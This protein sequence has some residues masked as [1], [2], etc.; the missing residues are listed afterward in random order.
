MITT[1]HIENYV[2]IDLLD[3]EFQRGLNIITGETGA[4]KSIL[5][6]AIGMLL[7]GR[8]DSSAVKNGAANCVIEAHFE[9]AD[10]NLQPLFDEY[11]L[12]YDDTM[13]VR[14][15]ITAQG[16]S[17][18][19]INELPV[20]LAQLKSIGERLIDIH[21]QHQ[22]LLLGDGGF[23][24]DVVDCVAQNE[25]LI[26]DY[27]DLM[28]SVRD[29]RA[30]HDAA[31]EELNRARRDEEFMRYQYEQLA[32]AKLKA[33]EKEELEA[34]EAVMAN[35]TQ[36]KEALWESCSLLDGESDACVLTSLRR[37]EGVLESISQHSTVAADLSERIS[38]A[39]Y[40]LK[41]ISEELSSLDDEISADPSE[42]ERLQARLDT[43]YTL[44]RKHN[45]EGVEPLIELRDSLAAKLALIDGS[46]DSIKE[47]AAQLDAQTKKALAVA[48]KLSKRRSAAL[49]G[50]RKNILSQLS[51]LGMEGARIEIEL[52]QGKELLYNGIDTIEFMFCANKGGKLERIAKVAS[53]GEMSRLMLSLKSLMASHRSLPTIIF[54]EID[55]G[56]SGSVAD[57]MGEIM[58]RLSAGKQIINITHLPQVAAKGNHHFYV[59]KTDK[60]GVTVT[61]IRKLSGQERVDKIAEMLSASRVTDAARKQAEELLGITGK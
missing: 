11:D 14:R 41:D 12:E 61:V 18:S 57:K 56:V 38:S 51:Q 42:L 49:P 20:T 4:G 48:S 31:V 3:I 45:V 16:K 2:L 8:T 6:G 33:G 1:L 50:I 25:A 55:T 58:E 39:Y 54:D 35:A 23:Q 21:S 46:D 7:G 52:T 36:I 9:V 19:Y 28:A 10:Y 32:E 37:V 34:Q 13:T 30:R 43:I 59:Y 5:L 27:R 15:V 29:L 44:E 26:A 53:G 47:L 17:R 24:M 22:T 40:E 60:N